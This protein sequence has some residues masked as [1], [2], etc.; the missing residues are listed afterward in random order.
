MVP[1]TPLEACAYARITPSAAIAAWLESLA[2]TSDDAAC[3]TLGHSVRGAPLR[4]LHCRR[5]RAEGGRRLRVMLVGSHHGGS[6]PAGGEALLVIARALVRGELRGLLDAL[7]VLIVPDANPDGRDADSSRNANRINLNRDYVLLSQP[8][9]RALDAAV[10]R[11]RPQIVLDAHESAAL[12]RRSLGREGWLT[13]FEAQFDVANNPALPA[14]L[15]D[16]GERVLLEEFIAR[17]NRRG[18]HA[19]RYVREIASTSQPLTHGGLTIRRFRNKAGVLGAWS[20]LLETRLDP[21]DGQYPS[22]RNIEV[23]TSKQVLCIREFLHAVAEQAPELEALHA[24]LP[25]PAPGEPLVLGADYVERAAGAL[26]HVPLRRIDTGE[27]VSLAFSDHRAVA[28][29]APLAAPR[30]WMLP[31][32]TSVFR[33][34][35]Q[36][37]GLHFEVLGASVE[38]ELI[39]RQVAN[40]HLDAP[41][42]LVE[43]AG[44]QRLRMPVGALRVPYTQPLGRLAALL[45]EPRSSS[46]VF[47]HPAYRRLLVPGRPLCVYHER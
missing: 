12:K 38:R 11:F 26:H 31:E 25:P 37:H 14:P 30:A 22:Y 10:R 2:G 27:V 23:R 5:V 28:P 39:A 6:E 7:E 29:H 3:L 35:L 42:E 44:P 33:E 20:F 45:L 32:H 17:V 40:V 15:R 4:A 8:E 47:A 16:H 34:L 41:A 19:Q 24:A 43:A 36:R 1:A 9:S 46:S 13:E 21:R 18:L